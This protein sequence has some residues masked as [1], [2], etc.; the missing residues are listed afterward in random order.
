MEITVQSE[1]H[2]AETET[3]D[4]DPEKIDTQEMMNSRIWKIK[5]ERKRVGEESNKPI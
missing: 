5:K 4:E 2:I 1:N 3:K